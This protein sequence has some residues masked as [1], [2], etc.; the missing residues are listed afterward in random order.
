MRLKE[1]LSRF[2]YNISN[3]LKIISS[4]LAPYTDRVY[5]VGGAVRDMLMGIRPSDADLEVFGI[6]PEPFDEIMQNLGAKG[7]G[8]SFFVYK[9]N[10]IDIA[11]PRTERK[12]SAGH[13]GFE[14]ALCKNEK[15]ASRRRDFTM[16]AL[17]LNLFNG[18]THDF[19]GGVRDIRRGCIQIIDKESFEEDSLRVLRAMQ[20]AARFGFKVTSEA[21]T[22]MQN[23]DLSDLTKERVVWEF[24]KLFVAEYPH[25]G[26][27]YLAALGILEKLLGISLSKKIFFQSAK[28]MKC[29]YARREK[30]L[31][32]YYFLYILSKNLHIS[33]TKIPELLKLPG[34]YRKHLKGQRPIP[35]RINRRFLAA[36]SI[37]YPIESWLGHYAPSVKT[38]AES[39][40]I[41]RNSFLGE[42]T[43]FEVMQ[44]GFL[45][46][47]IG[48][49]LLKRK[50]L[51]IKKYYN[52]NQI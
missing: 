15:E 11:L 20:F 39:M 12:V 37:N 22:V 19:W 27:F 28:E 40:G 7:V 29:A 8:K 24:E 25:Y 1:Y 2:P 42:V 50:L 9:W 23:M 41:Y 38:E 4:L 26:L 46:R 33:Q 16:N 36:L 43:P 5:I 30:G 21:C 48:R 10:R 17:M 49:E 34:I 18:E 44:E 31:E 3:D 13:R 52:L 47:D 14:V 35:L 32:H 6:D 45:G 51:E